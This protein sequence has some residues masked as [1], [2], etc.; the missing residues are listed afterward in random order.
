M[1][2]IKANGTKLNLFSTR[3]NVILEKN[4][5]NSTLFSYNINL[6]NTVLNQKLLK[7][8]PVIQIVSDN[9]LVVDN[10]VFVFNEVTETTISGNIVIKPNKEISEYL[11]GELKDIHIDKKIRSFNDIN[12]VNKEA[13]L[14]NSILSFP[15]ALYSVPYTVFKEDDNNIALQKTEYS[16]TTFHIGNIYPAYNVSKVLQTIFKQNGIKLTG[17]I[18]DD[19]VF[20]NLWQTASNINTYNEDLNIPRYCQFD[21]HYT[22]LLQNTVSNTLMR[23]TIDDVAF[24]S[25]NILLSDNTVIN[26]VINEAGLFDTDSDN[27]TIIIPVEG[28]Y[29]IFFDTRLQLIDTLSPIAGSNEAINVGNT[30]SFSGHSYEA[31]LD[32]KLAEIQ[33]LRNNTSNNQIYSRLLTY[34]TLSRVNFDGLFYNYIDFNNN[35]EYILYNVSR[36]LETYLKSPVNKQSVILKNVSEIPTDDFITGFRFGNQTFDLKDDNRQ[37][38]ASI[39]QTALTDKGN[40]IPLE[41]GNEVW[42]PLL[43]RQMDGDNIITFDSIVKAAALALYRDDSMS[44][45][46]DYYDWDTDYNKVD[47]GKT[48]TQMKAPYELPKAT[49]IRDSNTTANG[50]LS[51]VVWLNKGDSLSIN[52]ISP[53]NVRYEKHNNLITESNSCA[54]CDVL[55]G[56]FAIGLISGDRDFKPTEKFKL[57]QTIDELRAFM[58]VNAKKEQNINTN[59]AQFLGTGTQ[60]NW[61]QNVLNT[62]NLKLTYVSEKEYRIESNKITGLGNI[63][64][65][66]G[67]YSDFELVYDTNNKKENKLSFSE[68][69]KI[70]GYIKD[71][72][73]YKDIA[74]IENF[75]SSYYT[76]YYKEIVTPDNKYNS[77]VLSDASLWQK[78][79]I[80]AVKS[81]Q[82]SNP[83]LFCLNGD[84]ITIND[85][86]KTVL[87]LPLTTNS[88]DDFNIDY[89]DIFERYFNNKRL[90]K[91]YQLKAYIP[92]SL[93][94]Q[95]KL[96]TRFA[97]NYTTYKLQSIQYDLSTNIG[98]ITLF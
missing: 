18:L 45:F 40:Y 30:Q 17:S 84:T 74:V 94:Q 41:I 6:P 14:G 22:N 67:K 59:F 33:I 62:F 55:N 86:G 34:P 3:E 96:N 48:K 9:I 24:A 87:S 92:L 77:L 78:N 35:L 63:I 95:I 75:T 4:Y 61:V 21:Y 68:N 46:D 7:N 27:S 19:K 79:P 10:A 51:T 56:T 2:E 8:N 57:P 32:N 15:Y 43:H 53:Y 88:I 1:I 93:Y 83:T 72:G 52:L 13:R 5:I 65:I 25:D 60:Y 76:P 49:S 89:K 90:N 80:E 39:F 28:W 26:N 81:N 69:T 91:T 16:D 71:K 66:T 70:E 44:N 85:K 42:L 11:S 38:I 58:P 64:D 98:T 31:N 50:K 29:Q 12:E 82:T 73:S 97:I 20:T 37:T 47:I 23:A 36:M 54:V